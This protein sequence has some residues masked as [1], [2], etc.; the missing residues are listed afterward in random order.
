MTTV[1][2]PFLTMI[3]LATFAPIWTPPFA[4]VT[5]SGAVASEVGFRRTVVP[6]VALAKEAE[7]AEMVLALP[8]VGVDEYCMV[9]AVASFAVTQTDSSSTIISGPPEM[10]KMV[11]LQM[12]MRM[13]RRPFHT[14][15]TNGLLILLD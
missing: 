15:P 13:L 4:A 7:A 10:V 12:L 6:A 3:L 11:L 8:T 2:V 9:E 14:L 1:I 5:M